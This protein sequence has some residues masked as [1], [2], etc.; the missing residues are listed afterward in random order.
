MKAAPSLIWCFFSLWETASRITAVSSPSLA[1][2][3]A[4]WGLDNR[5]AMIRVIAG[6]G[7]NAHI[8][9]RIGEP[10][11]N[12]YLYMAS[13][14]L[15]GLDGVDHRI[16]PGPLSDE[17][18]SDTGRPYL[19]RSLMEAVE[20]LKHSAL[21]RAK[22]GDD[23]GVMQRIRTVRNHGYVFCPVGW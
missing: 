17:P 7:P 13:Q 20:A 14:I 15:A 1:P 12:P 5:A 2:D 22:L 19:P 4:T 23:D 10:A 18:Y 11:A 8:E 9:N 21:F 16:D 6:E 3:R